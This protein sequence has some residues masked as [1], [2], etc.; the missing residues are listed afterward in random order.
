MPQVKN[1]IKTV[2]T[3]KAPLP[4]GHYSQALIHGNTIYVAGQLGT[5]PNVV[6]PPPPGP[7]AQQT[8]Q[9]IRNIEAILQ[10]A[11][12]SLRS[13]LKVT[14]YVSDISLW[15]EVNEVYSRLFGDSRPARIILPCGLLRLGYQVSMDV[16]AAVEE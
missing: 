9:V 3:D 8:E 1:Q 13:V 4:R 15:D 2:R 12:S 16:I 5:P 6:P 11:G 7:I 10:A 14:V